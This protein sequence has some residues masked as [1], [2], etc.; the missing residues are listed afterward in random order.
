MN[1]H[2][3]HLLAAISGRLKLCFSAP[4]LDWRM[5]DTNWTGIIPQA[6]RTPRQLFDRQDFNLNSC[7]SYTTTAIK[8][9]MKDTKHYAKRFKSLQQ[10]GCSIASRQKMFAGHALGKT[11]RFKSRRQS[12]SQAAF[13]T[14]AVTGIGRG[15]TSLFK[16]HWQEDCEITLHP[17]LDA[18]HARGKTSGAPVQHHTA[19]SREHRNQTLRGHIGS[20]L[21]SG[22]GFWCQHRRAFPA[23]SQKAKSFSQ[24]HHGLPAQPSRFRPAVG[25]F[26]NA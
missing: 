8:N 24:N 23:M 21:F 10:A 16:S 18:G 26:L 20:L 9:R 14:R 7:M 3:I 2:L 1:G 11:K 19:H 25:P 12:E 17:G 15:K 22:Q 4:A 13:Q 5:T 6:G